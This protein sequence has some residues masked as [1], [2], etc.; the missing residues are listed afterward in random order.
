MLKNVEETKI[1]TTERK[2]QGRYDKSMVRKVH[3]WYET[4]MVRKVLHSMGRM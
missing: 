2:V 4:S 1:L 3:K